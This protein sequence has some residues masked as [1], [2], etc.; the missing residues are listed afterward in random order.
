MMMTERSPAVGGSVLAQF[1]TA[2]ATV[3]PELAG[4]VQAVAFDADT[5]LLAV[6]PDAPAVGAKVRWSTPKLIAAVNEMRPKVNVRALNQLHVQRQSPRTCPS[7]ARRAG[8]LVALLLS[9]LARDQGAVYVQR[10]PQC[11]DAAAGG[12]WFALSALG[13]AAVVGRGGALPRAPSCSTGSPYCL[14]Q[15]VQAVRPRF[16]GRLR[17]WRMAVLH[18][19][20]PQ[21]AGLSEPLV[22]G[23]G[24]FFQRR[25]K[26][27][28]DPKLRPQVLVLMALW[29]NK[30]KG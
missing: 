24:P 8:E 17:G 11:G 30:C 25:C 6:I 20:G 15:Q 2:L 12:E 7:W 19:A 21:G 5:S 18:V 26:S 28:L 23:E 22:R 14:A 29:A 1:D 3:V 4:R 27:R 10:R 13:L 9:H 16:V